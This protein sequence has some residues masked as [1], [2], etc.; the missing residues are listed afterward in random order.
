[1]CLEMRR[2]NEGGLLF[3]VKLLHKLLPVQLTL[4]QLSYAG[5]CFGNSRFCL[6]AANMFTKGV[7]ALQRLLYPHIW[8]LNLDKPC[9]AAQK[10]ST[11][12]YSLCGFVKLSYN[13]AI[14]LLVLKNLRLQKN[15][16][17]IKCRLL[18]DYF[19]I[20][21][22]TFALSHYSAATQ[23]ST[24]F[25][26]CFFI[27]NSPI[28]TVTSYRKQLLSQT[29]QLAINCPLLQCPVSIYTR[30]DVSERE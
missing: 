3:L 27:L 22:P 20:C 28:L 10:A 29:L 18:I 8:S 25:A 5:P 4:H 16:C 7:V 26:H 6:L 17:L 15:S 30:L 2:G 14:K 9:L 19:L 23:K 1:M 21:V 12:S 24:E 13:L 11:S